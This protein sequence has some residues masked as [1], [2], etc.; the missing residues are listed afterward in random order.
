M[1]TVPNRAVLI[2]EL[3]KQTISPAEMEV[4][5]HWKNKLNVKQTMALHF[6]AYATIRSQ[7]NHFIKKMKAVGL[8]RR[9]FWGEDNN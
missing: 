7:R 1:S 9:S 3:V 6:R 4:F 8:R 2:E 5:I